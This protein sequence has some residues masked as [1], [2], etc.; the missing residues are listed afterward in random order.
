MARKKK[1]K[2]DIAELIRDT[3]DELFGTDSMSM[4]LVDELDIIA[5][6]VATNGVDRAKEE[7]EMKKRWVTEDL[8]KNK[9]NPKLRGSNAAYASALEVLSKN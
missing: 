9:D 3:A 2:E 1:T 5:D 7:I 8:R 4:A 6:W